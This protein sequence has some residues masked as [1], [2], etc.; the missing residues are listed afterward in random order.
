MILGEEPEIGLENEKKLS[1]CIQVLCR[2]GFSP[3]PVDIL[4]LVQKYVISNSLKTKFVDSRP[5]KSKLDAKI[6]QKT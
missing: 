3:K 2:N 6:S 5:T 1:K 4:D